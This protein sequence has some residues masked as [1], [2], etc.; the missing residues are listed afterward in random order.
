MTDNTLIGARHRRLR[1]H[2]ESE[3]FWSKVEAS[4]VCLEWTAG[5]NQDGYGNFQLSDTG[6]PVAAHVWAYEHLIGPVPIGMELDHL[7]RNR[8]CVDPSHTQPV[9]HRINVLRGIGLAAQNACKTHCIRKHEFTPENTYQERNGE[10]FRRVCR[11]CR[12]ARDARRI[13]R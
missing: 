3:R 11:T 12:R 13:R 2:P 6:A 7:C 10:Q 8:G 1:G 4:G 5:R 9:P